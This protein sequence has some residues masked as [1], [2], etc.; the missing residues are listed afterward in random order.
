[1]RRHR[2]DPYRVLGVARGATEGPDQGRSPKAGQALPPGRLDGRRAALP[3]RPR[4]ISAARR[5]PPPP[6]V[7]RSSRAGPRPRRRATVCAAPAPPTPRPTTHPPRHQRPARTA[8]RPARCR[9]GR[10]ACAPRIGAS[11]A[12]AGRRRAT[13]RRTTDRP[14]ARAPT[15]RSTTVP[16]APPGRRPPAN[17]SAVSMP[18]CHKRGQFRHQGTQPLTAARARVAA[19]EEA[20][21]QSRQ[22]TPPPP[23]PPVTPP[24][25]RPTYSYAAG[26]A[27]TTEQV[28]AARAAT[29]RAKRAAAWPSLRERLLIALIAWVPVAL[30]I[31]YGGSPPQPA[32]VL[33]SAARPGTRRSK[34][35]SSP[36]HWA[37]RGAPARGLCR[38]LRQPVDPRRQHRAGR[39]AGAGPDPAAAA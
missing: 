20:R 32:T 1:M 16:A 15:S 19:D 33:P 36:W 34:R 24:P 6:R 4:G 18:T 30:L 5:P 38:G 39:T 9:G 31:G 27:H 11:P 12:R 17:T 29:Q 22:A 28:N 3:R 23:R 21:A 8:G 7:G 37:A 10:R 13:C 35:C 14:L 2:C 26:V 25:P